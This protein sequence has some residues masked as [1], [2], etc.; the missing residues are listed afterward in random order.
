MET[1]QAG[2]KYNERVEAI[3]ARSRLGEG[4]VA[5]ASLSTATLVAALP[6]PL[7]AQA[8]ALAWAAATA[9]LALRR[10]RPGV[11]IRVDH[12]GG[13]TVDGAPGA[14]RDGCFVAPWLAILRWRPDGARRDRTLL[15]AP[16][17]LDAEAFRRLRVILRWRRDSGSDH[18]VRLCSRTSGPR[19]QV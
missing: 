6:L 11:H 12:A 19:G 15:V 14:L 1:V 17:M 7:E 4:F 13:L 9:L 18:L 16:D 5:C 3:L 8:G 10:L 2:D